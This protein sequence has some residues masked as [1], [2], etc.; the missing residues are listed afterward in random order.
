MQEV[1]ELLAPVA[2]DDAV[3]PDLAYDPER[4]TIEAAFESSVSDDGAGEEIDWR[5]IIRLIEGQ[6]ART[7]DLWLAAYLA[8]AGARSGQFDVVITGIEFFAGLVEQYWPHVHP[9]LDEVGFQGRKAP[10]E[11]LTSYAQ[12]LRPLQGVILLQ[13]ARLGS[14]S[15]SDFERFANGGTDADGYGMF[16]AAID[17]NPD[18]L[19]EALDRLDRL[20]DG[21]RRIDAVM[22]AQAGGDETST[23]FAPACEA[24]DKIRRSV[25]T[26]AGE[27]DASP[28]SGAQVSAPEASPSS[29][30]GGGGGTGPAISGRVESRED[31]A[32]ALDAIIDYYRRREPGS[33][34]PVL[35]TRARDWLGADFLTLMQDIAPGGMDE[36]RRVLVSQRDE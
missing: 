27:S 25:G 23:N 36:V 21:I 17:D 24:L 20:R 34:V 28:S 22:T 1:A 10:A 8:R 14:Y 12:F 31:V 18:A 29:G 11:G 19:R 7:K 4:A 30:S 16:R 35:L 15:G 32:R 33:P 3:G 6:S 9:Q 26:F 13:H 2:D 5:E